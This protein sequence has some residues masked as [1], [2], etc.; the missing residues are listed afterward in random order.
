[1][2]HKRIEHSIAVSEQAV[3]LAGVHGVCIKQAEIAGLLH[4]IC[5]EMGIEEQRLMISQY[6]P[7]EDRQI[8]SIKAI[9]HSL[10]GPIFVKNQIGIIDEDVLNAIRYHTTGRKNM[11]RLEKI[12][13]LADRTSNDRFYPDVAHLRQLSKVNLD[14][15]VLFAMKNQ[16]QRSIL[17]GQILLQD[18]VK[19]YNSLLIESNKK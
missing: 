4:D 13:V 7:D 19:A 1:L 5:K 11:S 16:I 9:L 15:A 12:I 17:E 14:Q 10:S 2:S 8:L 6:A 3:Y 18:T